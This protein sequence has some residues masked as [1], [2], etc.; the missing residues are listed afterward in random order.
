MDIQTTAEI[1]TEVFNTTALGLGVLLGFYS[2]YLGDYLRAGI[3]FF[4]FVPLYFVLYARFV[5]TE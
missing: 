1:L 2:L 4:V 3:I 5:E